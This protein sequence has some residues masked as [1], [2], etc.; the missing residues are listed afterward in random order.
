MK[1]KTFYRDMCM[2]AS[3]ITVIGMLTL[4]GAGD[5]RVVY[6]DV[7]AAPDILVE[8]HPEVAESYVQKK[9]TEKTII[10]ESWTPERKK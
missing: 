5:E 10:A 4:S 9:E 6:E 1:E 8:D 2:V 3:G 7:A